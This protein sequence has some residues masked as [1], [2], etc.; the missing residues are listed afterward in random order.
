LTYSISGTIT[1]SDGGTANGA[2]LTILTGPSAG[3]ATTNTSGTYTISGLLAGSYTIEVSLTGYVTGTISLTVSGTVSN[4]NL[5]LQLF[6]YTVSYDVSSGGGTAPASQ[7]VIPGASITLPSWATMTAPAGSGNDLINWTAHAVTYAPG[8]TYTV[9]GDVTFSAGWSPFTSIAAVTSRLAAPTG[10]GGTADPIPLKVNI[11]LS[12]EW[13]TL[14]STLESKSKYVAL[15]L[16]AST[17]SGTEFDPGSGSTGVGKIVSLTLPTAAQS[18]R[19]RGTWTFDYFTALKEIRG[20]NVT[21]IDD[22]TFYTCSTLSTVSFPAASSI[23]ERAFYNCSALTSVSLPAATSIGD[24]AFRDCSALTSV[25][26][27]AASSIGDMAFEGC[28]TLTSVTLP[29]A[30]SIG[31]YAFY[32][33]SALTSVSLPVASSI[34]DRAFSGCIALTT[35]RLPAAR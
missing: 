9:T 15:D 35:V 25:S 19:I 3:A 16:S 23:G 17:L 4:Q 8:A 29:A 6:T 33:C 11:S 2:A 32:D 30:S 13:G 34:G 28:S 14:L 5:T 7:S 1:K 24:Y 31:N 27:P 18:I 21:T 22:R 26:L 10:D 12:S 20:S